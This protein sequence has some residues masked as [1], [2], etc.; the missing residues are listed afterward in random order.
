MNN[1]QKKEFLEVIYDL[2]TVSFELK[3]NQLNEYTNQQKNK[4]K[5]LLYFLINICISFENLTIKNNNN[6]SS[7]SVETIIG[8][9]N[10]ST[11]STST[12]SKL[13]EFN[14]IEWRGI[15]LEVIK[16]YLLFDQSK[17]WSMSLIQENYLMLIWKYIFLLL[18][19]KSIGLNGIGKN[20]I[21]LK[22]LC[23]EIITK[24]IKQLDLRGL[25]QPIDSI[26][27][28]ITSLIDSLCR[29]EQIGIYLA[30]IFGICSS[31]SLVCH[32]IMKEIGRINM[33]EFSK[34]NSN[35]VKNIGGFLINLGEIAPETIVIFLPL[36]LNHLDSDAYQIR[37]A[38]LLLFSPLFFYYLTYIY[39]FVSSQ[40]LHCDIY[41][42]DNNTYL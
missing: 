4:I 36:I 21:N 20:E 39:Y 18:E 6:I 22:K 19:E 34:N 10:K 11:K 7:S 5:I 1:E 16:K 12:K 13:K 41:W 2:T 26:S 40:K 27:S 25:Q 32:E 17:F 42:L 14:W 28:F 35:G 31:N 29:Y 3:N 24:C 23:L 37:F 15:Y 33:N 30:E 9:S 8:K 38:F